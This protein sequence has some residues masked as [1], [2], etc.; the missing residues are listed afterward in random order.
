MISTRA[1]FAIERCNRDEKGD[2]DEKDKPNGCWTDEEID[3]YIS[4]LI[5]DVWAT[6]EKINYREYTNKPVWNVY[7]LYGTSIMDPKLT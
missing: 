2:Y 6:Y 3:I 1:E 5:V 7:D 4:D